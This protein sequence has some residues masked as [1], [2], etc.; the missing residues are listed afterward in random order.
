MPSKCGGLSEKFI[1][2]ELSNDTLR[3][4][5]VS[6]EKS[7]LKLKNCIKGGAFLNNHDSSS[8]LGIMCL[9]VN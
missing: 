6:E 3:S 1:Q 5:D 8:N 7:E 2:I 9:S 4:H